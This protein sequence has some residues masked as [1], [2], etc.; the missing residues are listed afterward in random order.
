MLAATLD[1]LSGG[2]FNLGLGAG[3]ADFLGWVGIDDAR[4]A[5]TMREASWRSAPGSGAARR[6][7]GRFVREPR[8]RVLALR[9]RGG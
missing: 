9:A 6:R 7:A 1:E 2:R 3:A 8:S 5:A 4:P